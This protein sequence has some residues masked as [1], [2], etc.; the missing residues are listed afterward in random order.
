LKLEVVGKE[1]DYRV[2]PSTVMLEKGRISKS[3]K[4]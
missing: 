2:S 4:K 1:M 3:G